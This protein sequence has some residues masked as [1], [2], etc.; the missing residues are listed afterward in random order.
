[1]GIWCIFFEGLYESKSK[2]EGAGLVRRDETLMD[3]RGGVGP[4]G[5][6]IAA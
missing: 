5:P 4:P 3:I 2:K 6:P 1:M